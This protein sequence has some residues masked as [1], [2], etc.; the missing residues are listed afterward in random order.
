MIG[1]D[2]REL[3]LL[4]ANEPRGVDER[5]AWAEKY[6]FTSV[7]GRISHFDDVMKMALAKVRSSPLPIRPGFALRDWH[8]SNQK[9]ARK[10][11]ASVLSD[12][13]F[14]RFKAGQLPSSVAEAVEERVWDLVRGG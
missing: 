2:L 13:R 6:R 10:I 1:K 11:V 12:D 4:P 5:N 8:K 3:L 9:E 14:L 7:R